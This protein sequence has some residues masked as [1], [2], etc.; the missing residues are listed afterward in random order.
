MNLKKYSNVL[1][2]AKEAPNFQQYCDESLARIRL[3][4]A[5]YQERIAQKLTIKQLAQK[6]NTTSAIISRLENAQFSANISLVFKIFR[7]LGKDK[8][9]LYC[10]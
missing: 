1:A 9:E 2:S 3:A 4:E 5:I 10:V 8:I 6:A 7:A